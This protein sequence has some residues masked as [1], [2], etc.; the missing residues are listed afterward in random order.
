MKPDINEL[1]SM[2]SSIRPTAAQTGETTN[3]DVATEMRLN[4]LAKT[5]GYGG[6]SISLA[7]ERPNDPMF[8]WRNSNLPYNIWRQEIGRAH[9]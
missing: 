8:Y 1:R 4:R 7:A 9:V 6:G 2:F 5:G 3:Q